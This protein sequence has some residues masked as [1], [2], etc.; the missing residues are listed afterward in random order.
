MHT[1]RTEHWVEFLHLAM[2]AGDAH[3]IVEY[4]TRLG[5]ETRVVVW[6]ELDG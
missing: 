1:L 3:C 2:L 5:L 4:W 6:E